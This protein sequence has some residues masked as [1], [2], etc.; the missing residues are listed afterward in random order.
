MNCAFTY[1]QFIKA[2]PILNSLQLGKKPGYRS[3]ILERLQHVQEF[4]LNVWNNNMLWIIFKCTDLDCKPHRVFINN[5]YS[6]FHGVSITWVAKLHNSKLWKRPLNHKQ[7][8]NLR[9]RRQGQ[10]SKATTKNKIEKIAQN[11]V[12]IYSAI[13]Q[14]ICWICPTN[15]RT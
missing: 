9:G 11:Q 10:T 14:S 3:E 8:Q 13:C 6:H 4:M 15:C 12:D 7:E 1:T 2:D 5:Y